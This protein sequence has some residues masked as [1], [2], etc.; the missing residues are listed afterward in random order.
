MSGQ[1]KKQST[2]GRSRKLWLMLHRYIALSAGFVFVILGLTGACNV[3]YFELEELGLPDVAQENPARRYSLDKIMAAIKQANPRRTAG[4]TLSMP[5]HDRDYIWVNYAKPEETAD[6][7]FAPLRILVHPYTGQPVEENYWGQTL[8]SLVYEV[9]AD[10]LLGKLGPEVGRVGFKVVTFLGAFLFISAVTGLYLWWPKPGKFICA[11]TMKKNASPQRWHYD[12]HKIT[13]FYSAL[14]FIIVAVSG[15][16]FGYFDYIKA[17]VDCFSPVEAVHHKDPK[18]F[19]STLT[20]SLTTIPIERA[21]S[22]ADQIFP[23]AQLRWIA[24]P[25]G[26]EGVYAIE[27]RQAGEANQRRP[28]SKVWID[29]YSGAILAIEDPRQFTAGETF[30]NL[31][32][33]LHSG[34]ALGMPGRI[35]WCLLGLTPLLMFVTGLMRWLHKRGAKRIAGEKRRTPSPIVK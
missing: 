3:F 35:L 28:R 1:R 31:M 29:Q 19:K 22:I 12:V 25:D 16:S 26:K 8:W 18:T 7:F 23:D 11:V 15:F 17:A 24:L 27:K 33:P 34:E 4:W 5:G 2:R 6:E 9:H 30:L 32:W 13:G 10:L 14:F 21:V 20:T